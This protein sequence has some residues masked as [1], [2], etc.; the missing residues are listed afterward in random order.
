MD[1]EQLLDILDNGTPKEKLD[2]ELEI[3]GRF[4]YLND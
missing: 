3:L 1:Y 2:A 4:Y